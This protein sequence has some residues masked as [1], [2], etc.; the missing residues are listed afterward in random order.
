MDSKKNNTNMKKETEALNQDHSESMAHIAGLMIMGNINQDH[1]IP[2]FSGPDA[3]DANAKEPE[4]ILVKETKADLDASEDEVAKQLDHLKETRTPLSRWEQELLNKLEVQVDGSFLIACGALLQIADHDNGR[5]W[6]SS[7]KEF[8][9]YVKQRFGYTARYCALMIRGAVFNQAVLDTGDGVPL[10]RESHIRPIIQKVPEEKRVEFWKNFCTDK[11]ITEEN[12]G[13]LKA[14]VIQEA[15]QEAFPKD[16]PE[17][18]EPDV[19]PDKKEAK[20]LVSSL[21]KATKA[22]PNYEQIEEKLEEISKLLKGSN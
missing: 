8:K 20:K 10:T 12:V 4:A 18:D 13:R 2:G 9:D 15:V 1:P 11:G 3:D 16:N 19:T 22:L 17:A 6:K 5:L 21:K 14:K 7:H